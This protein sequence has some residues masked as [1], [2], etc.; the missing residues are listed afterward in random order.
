MSFMDKLKNRMQMGKGHAKEATGRET[1]DP[2]LESEGRRDRAA[3]GV[4]QV[5]EHAKDAVRNVK[6]SF[7]R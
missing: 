6:K 4:K 3:G 2:Y 5:G 7:G 1:R